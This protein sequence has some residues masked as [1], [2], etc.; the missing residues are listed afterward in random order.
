[1]NILLAGAFASGSFQRIILITV[2][3]KPI[4]H[5]SADINSYTI[6]CVHVYKEKYRVNQSGAVAEDGYHVVTRTKTKHLGKVSDCF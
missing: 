4:L 3:P 6:L 5:A 1:M 2:K